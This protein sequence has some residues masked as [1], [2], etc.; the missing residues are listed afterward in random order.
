MEVD[1]TGAAI[2]RF[3]RI[4]IAS[5]ARSCVKEARRA[6]AARFEPSTLSIAFV[7]DREMARLN[8]AYRGK[9]RTTDVLTFE[10]E[11]EPDG[12]R[13]LGEIVISIERAKAQAREEQHSLATEVRYLILHG[14]LHAFG[15]DHENDSGEMNALELELR[16]RV[17]LE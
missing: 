5:F 12:S 16:H 2:P 11:E 3:P 8:A 7:D 10:G 4:A 9:R 13:P 15:W 14:V 17:G 1:I 6:R